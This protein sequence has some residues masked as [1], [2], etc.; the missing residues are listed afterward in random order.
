M[1]KSSYSLQPL[2]LVFGAEVGTSLPRIY[3]FSA[4]TKKKKKRD[5]VSS[6]EFHHQQ[7]GTKAT[8]MKNGKTPLTNSPFR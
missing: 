3:N 1:S 2:F 8:G 5:Q 7:S 6:T 4:L